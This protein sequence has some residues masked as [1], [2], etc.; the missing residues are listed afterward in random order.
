[1]IYAE[2]KNIKTYKGINK[3]LDKAIDFIIEKKYL[4]AFTGTKQVI[5]NTSK[6][7]SVLYEKQEAPDIRL[8]G[9]YLKEGFSNVAIHKL[10]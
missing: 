1:M 10:E 3:N 4:N 8:P 5:N 6:Q 7:K 9:I 2:L